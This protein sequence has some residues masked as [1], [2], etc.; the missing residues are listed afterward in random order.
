VSQTQ[1]AQIGFFGI[2]VLGTRTLAL[3]TGQAGALRARK[4]EAKKTTNRK[5][6]GEAKA[7]LGVV[8]GVELGLQSSLSTKARR[9]LPRIVLNHPLRPVT[10]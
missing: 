5:Q 7:L 6:E 4:I 3:V 8:S 10:S 1:L 9:N 2:P